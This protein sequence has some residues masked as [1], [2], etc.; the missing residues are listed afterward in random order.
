[1]TEPTTRAR[2]QRAERKIQLLE[3]MIESKSLEVFDVHQQLNAA[4]DSL[5]K[6]LQVMPGALIVTDSDGK[7]DRINIATQNLL[8]Y[9]E[10]SVKGK[11]AGI[12]CDDLVDLGQTSAMM[13]YNAQKEQVWQS[14]AC[15]SIPMLVAGASYTSTDGGNGF[16]FVGTDL[17]ERKQMEMELRHA[18]KLESIG[19]LAAGVA[20]EI[21]TPMQFIGDNAYFLQESI[22]DLL[23]LIATYQTSKDTIKTVNAELHKQLEQAEE[24]ADLEYLVER[25]PV[26]AKRTLEGVSRVSEIVSAMK[27][28]S[29]PT[30]E[31]SLVD[32]NQAVSTTLTVAKNEYKYVAEVETHLGEL[33]NING[34]GGDLNQ[35][36]LNLVVNS[37]H[38]ISE[39]HQSTPGKITI[40]TYAD[41]DYVYILIADTGTGIPKHIQSRIYDPFFTTK[42][43]GKGT[44]QGLSLVY[45]TIVEKHHGHISFS[46]TDGEG[47]EFRIKLP[48]KD[49]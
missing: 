4:N 18:Q 14:S 1:M 10:A 24:D 35:A 31:K 47:T 16:I 42:P 43:V 5:I 23:S 28:F 33:P 7:I 36:L 32:I 46:S 39:K 19:Q 3:E 6:L 26:A 9:S 12:I 27:A 29:H 41:Q 48:I 37:A 2:L 38:A 30:S 13:E 11:D 49:S 17:R 25:A 20:H 40:S 21:N 34:H 44:G 45:A 22:D 15:E 8:G